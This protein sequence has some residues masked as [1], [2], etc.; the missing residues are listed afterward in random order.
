MGLI[1]DTCVFIDAERNK[2]SIDFNQWLG[3]ELAYISAITASELLAGV[4]LAKSEARRL[5]RSAF[6]EAI[7]ARIPVLPFTEEVARMHA[8]IYAL[9]HSK[10]SLIGAHDLIIAAT[11]LAQGYS[12]LTRNKAEFERIA[13]L[14]VIYYEVQEA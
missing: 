2:H 12:L 1:L 4:F 3:E 7:L 10:G 13:G 6:V 8:E 14:N 9:L 11:A 5:K